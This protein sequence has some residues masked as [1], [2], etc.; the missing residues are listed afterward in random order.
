MINRKKRTTLGLFGFLG[1]LGLAVILGN[2]VIKVDL[3][4]S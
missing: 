1:L 2:E 3:D 4:D